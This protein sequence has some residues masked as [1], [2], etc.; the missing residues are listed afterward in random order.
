M[1]PEK[2]LQH[3]ADML[4]YLYYENEKIPPQ[5][6]FESYARE[7]DVRQLS[8]HPDPVVVVEN[9]ELHH[10]VSE[11]FY[12]PPISDNGSPET[13]SSLREACHHSGMWLLSMLE[14]LG[15]DVNNMFLNKTKENDRITYAFDTRIPLGNLSLEEL[16]ARVK[17]LVIKK[18]TSSLTS[19]I[20]NTIQN[21]ENVEHYTDAAMAIGRAVTEATA[22]LPPEQKAEFL[23]AMHSA[24]SG[25]AATSFYSKRNTPG[26]P[27]L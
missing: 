19:Q 3:M 10:T 14:D 15:F 8:G 13:M 12:H 16:R 22:S 20:K 21:F 24:I 17:E 6:P 23:Q 4:N 27:G 5:T 7:D 9:G 25:R 1:R 2:E 11:V 18:N 26:G